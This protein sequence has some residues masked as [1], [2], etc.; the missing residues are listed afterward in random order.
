LAIPTPRLFDR[1]KSEPE[2]SFMFHV[3]Y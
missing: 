2:D 3:E 1:R